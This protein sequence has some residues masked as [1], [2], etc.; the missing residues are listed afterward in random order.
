M[1]F[2]TFFAEAKRRYPV[3]ADSFDYFSTFLRDVD[4]DALIDAVT[5]IIS[6]ADI[7]HY[8]KLWL[9]TRRLREYA[10]TWWKLN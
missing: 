5:A 4:D 7:E 9:V 8:A 6:R 2:D 1:S 10:G 3:S